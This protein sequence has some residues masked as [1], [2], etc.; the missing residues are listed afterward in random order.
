M[1]MTEIVRYLNL[2]QGSDAINL[3]V[4]ETVSPV[5]FGVAYR[6]VYARYANFR[7]E[8]R[9]HRVIDIQT[10]ESFGHSAVLHPVSEIDEQLIAAEAVFVLPTD[11]LE[12]IYLDRLVRTLHAL[13]YL[14]QP[15]RGR[16]FLPVHLR[17]V[18]SVKANHGLAFEEILTSCGLQPQQMILEVA[19]DGVEDTE[20]LRSAFQ[21]YRNRGYQVAVHRFGRSACDLSLVE[22]LQP[23]VVRLDVSLLENPELLQ[24]VVSD[25]K[26]KGIKALGY[27]FG[28]TPLRAIGDRF[29]LDLIE[30]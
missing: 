28:A 26:G 5:P 13:N 1:P 30:Q 14:L 3:D 12:F 16:L 19:I 18:L 21:N 10:G 15:H 22:T 2:R 25:L 29:G 24:L 9:F 4:R 8:S 6:A 20:K 23:Q 7:L 27:G 11:D 17:H